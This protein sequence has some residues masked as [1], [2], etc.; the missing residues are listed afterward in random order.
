MEYIIQAAIVVGIILWFSI[1]AIV[2][3]MGIVSFLEDLIISGLIIGAL[4]VTSL[5]LCIAVF[6]N[7][8]DSNDSNQE[9]CGPG[10]EYRESRH[11]NPSTR[12]TH[13]DWWCETK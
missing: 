3:F 1:S 11:Y 7:L 12:S 13:T 4:G 6:A 2:G 5:I 9:H 8:A 10:T